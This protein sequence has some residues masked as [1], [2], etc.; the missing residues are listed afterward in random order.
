MEPSISNPY[1]YIKSEEN[2]FKTVRIP[3]T[4][5]KDWNMAEYIERCTNVANG[6]YHTGNNDGLR[7]YDDIVT[8][9]KNVALRSEGFDVKD[10]VPF[11]NSSG[12]YGLSF[13]VKKYH[14]QWAR[15]HELDTF[16]DDMVE[17]S[18][19]YDLALIKNVN[20]ERPEVVPLQQIAFCDQTNVLA[21]P[22]CLKYSYS[23]SE[24]QDMSSKWDTNKVEELIVLSKSQKTVNTSTGEKTA[25]T[26]GKNIEVYELHGSLPESWLT[27]DGDPD[28]YV[29]QMHIIS[30]YT[31]ES[32]NK[33]GITLFKGKETKP[34]F[35]SLVISKVYGRA[36]GRSIIETLFEPQVWN[37]YSGIKLKK[38]IDAVSNSVLHTDSEELGGK[39]ID[40]LKQNTILKM[41]QGRTLGAVQFDTQGVTILANDMQTKENKARILGSASDAQLG[42]SPSSGTPFA[43]QNLVVQQGQGIHEYRQGK[44]ATFMADQLYR[45]WI[46]AYLVKDMNGGKTFSEILTLEEMQEVAKLVIANQMEEFKINEILKGNI[47]TPEELLSTEQQFNQNFN[48]GGSRK[49]FEILAEELNDIP[50]DV[51]VNIVGKQKN[52]AK[53]ADIITNLIREILSNAQAFQQNPEIGSAV[54]E[55]LED[56]GMSPINFS[57]IVPQPT[58]LQPTQQPQLQ[59]Q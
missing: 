54:N 49:F 5:S 7:P 9:I 18:V 4:G 59:T 43:L 26:T 50:I 45:D 28:K 42:V 35:K 21:G 3:I 2:T 13:L 47:P 6:W 29:N 8:P 25:R 51:Y 57:R 14:P 10:I 58:Q 1:D 44:I 30:Y 20:N 52:L 34:I 37:N 27:E 24:L 39:K 32:G 22:L 55:L 46:L 48:Q 53:N 33:A 12:K 36:C 19:V 31:L 56:S 40:D 15:K 16:I 17:S 11:V 23:P 41:E 38:L